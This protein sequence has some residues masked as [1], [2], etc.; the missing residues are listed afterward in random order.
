MLVGIHISVMC[1]SDGP[2]VSENT[3]LYLNCVCVTVLHM[4]SGCFLRPRQ[5]PMLPTPWF[6]P[7]EMSFGFSLRTCWC[8]LKLSSSVAKNILI[9]ES[10]V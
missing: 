6:G 3:L 5:P 1:A 9:G 8:L 4:P 10:S 2:V 7:G